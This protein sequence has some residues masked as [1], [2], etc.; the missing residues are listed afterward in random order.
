M[1]TLTVSKDVSH[2]GA[3]SSH[4]RLVWTHLTCFLL[5]KY[6]WTT[7]QVHLNCIKLKETE[8]QPIFPV[9]KFNHI[10]RH[11]RGFVRHQSLLQANQT[12]GR[13]A[14]PKYKI[15]FDSIA[16]FQPEW[17]YITQLVDLHENTFQSKQVSQ[18]G[19]G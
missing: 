7:M 2:C 12:C 14:Q 8:F 4:T 5:F 15:S 16:E 13:R 19:Q 3:L 9:R 18:M 17:S 1:H 11:W 6:K 10:E